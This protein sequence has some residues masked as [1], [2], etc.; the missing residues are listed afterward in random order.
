MRMTLIAI[1]VCL[2]A[3]AIGQTVPGSR[4]VVGGAAQSAPVCPSAD[5]TLTLITAIAQ[6]DNP[7]ILSLTSS[8]GCLWA[9]DG[10]TGTVVAQDGRGLVQV[11]FVSLARMPQALRRGTYWIEGR[12]LHGAPD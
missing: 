8:Q 6:G 7:A 1:A 11:D 4:V 10:S 5:D 2:P 9:W 12:Y 3:A